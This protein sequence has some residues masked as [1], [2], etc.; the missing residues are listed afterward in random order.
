MAITLR[1]R[2]HNIRGFLH[3]HMA[4]RRSTPPRKRSTPAPVAGGGVLPAA[5]RVA[6]ASVP[7]EQD[8]SRQDLVEALKAE[9]LGDLEGMLRADPAIGADERDTLMSSLAAAMG[10]GT[11]GDADLDI[12]TALQSSAAQLKRLAN[13]LDADGADGLARQLDEALAPLERRETKL[14]MEFSR[15]LET[16]GQER[17]LAWLKQQQAV[18]A[19]QAA[20]KAS[21][22]VVDTGRTVAKDSVTRS[23][24]RRLRGPP[25]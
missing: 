8:G 9:L 20:S 21:P 1:Y 19:E 5:D 18:E 15:R 22:P 2:F 12:A 24:S 25:G 13:E 10:D 16:D 11:G 23:R 6:T 14:A 17:A 4:I 7:Q 3:F